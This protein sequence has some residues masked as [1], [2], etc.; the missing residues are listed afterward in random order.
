M[1]IGFIGTGVMGGGMARNLITKGEELLIVAR[2]AEVRE[3]LASLGASVSDRMADAAACPCV[4]LCLPDIAAVENV[5]LD[6]DGLLAHMAPGGMI[7]D[8]S[9]TSYD[10]ARALAAQCARRGVDFLDAPISGHRERAADGTLTIMCGGPEAAFNRVK[11]LLDKLGTTVLYM[12]G[13]G[14]GQLTKTIN[15]CALNICT[16]SFCELMPLGVKLGLAPE[17]LGQV[18]MTA[19]GASTA[20]KTLIPEILEGRFDHGFTLGRAY[21]DMENLLALTTGMA[22]PLPTFL[23]TLQTYQLALQG[24]QG[25]RYKGAMI[26]FYEELLGVVCRAPGAE[27]AQQEEKLSC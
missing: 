8:Y 13:S 1:K 14:S 9:T 6:S 16:A 25:A 18:L 3:V 22:L 4:F 21:K 15:N 26:R 10:A 27:K 12:G 7:V 23:G 17:K 19:S 24:G 5:V 20:S 2:R 11:P